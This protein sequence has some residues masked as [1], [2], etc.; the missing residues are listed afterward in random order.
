MT[1]LALV[2]ARRAALAAAVVAAM[3]LLLVPM[4]RAQEVPEADELPDSVETALIGAIQVEEGEEIEIL[5]VEPV[6]WNN[7]CLGVEEEGEACTEALVDGF[8]VWVS[9]GDT[10]YRYHTDSTSQVILAED[11][12]DPGDVDGAELPEGATAREPEATPTTP[13]E[14]TGIISGEIPTSGVALFTVTADASVDEIRAAL[15][16]QGCNAETLAKTVD[17]TWYIYSYS[18]PDFVTAAFFASDNSETGMVVGGTNLLTNCLGGGT[19][20]TPTPSPTVTLTPTPT[21]EPGEFSTD[22][23]DETDREGNGA[24]ADVQVSAEDGSERIMFEFATE[25][26]TFELVEGVPAYEVSYED[27]PAQCGSGE[28]VEIDGEAMLVVNFP[29][30]YSYDPEE[31]TALVTEPDLGDVEHILGVEQSCAFEGV[32]TWVFGIDSE[33]GF[34]VSEE[35]DPTSL[36][37]DIETE[38]AAT[39]TPTP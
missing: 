9:A 12:I 17:G 35:S 37:I 16:A 27:S 23:V 11:G 3:V 31:G 22:P 28:A 6:T 19:T 32:S 18:A 4:A 1:S 8:V 2:P 26:G 5:R 21:A 7:G 14:E 20:P 38:A 39:A 34:S 13:P 25:F 15:D 29:T 33:A 24:L 36:V 10:V 30:T